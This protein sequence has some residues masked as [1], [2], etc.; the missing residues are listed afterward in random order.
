VSDSAKESGEHLEIRGRP[1]A[2]RRLNRKTIMM[3]S[4][5]LL[6][7]VLLTTIWSLRGSRRG[8]AL[9]TTESHNV[10]HVS[11]PEGLDA[12]PHDYGSVAKIP[13]LGPPIGELGRPIVK[14]EQLAGL[15]PMPERGNFRPD[16]EE[17]A[18]RTEALRQESE[19]KEAARAPVFFQLSQHD[20]GKASHGADGGGTQQAESDLMAV[21]TG[22]APSNALPV[23]EKP[24]RKEAFLDRQAD[25]NLYALGT[26]QIPRS[27]DELLAGTVIPAA[28]VTGINSDLPGEVIATVTETVYDTITGKRA[29]IP[30][31]SRLLGQYDSQ[32]SFG[33][34]RLLL[35]WTR[36]IRPDGSSI[37]LDRLNGVDTEGHAGLQDKIDGHWGRVFAG[38]AVSTLVGVA[39]AL[40][41]PDRTTGSGTLVIASQQS[42]QDSVNQVGQQIT[43]RNIDIQPTLN[44]RPGF[45]LRVIV[46]KDLILRPYPTDDAA[47]EPS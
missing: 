9:T 17:D 29:L 42:V 23:G 44:I 20:Q 14:A 27:P 43:R 41:S 4:A 25:A 3:A 12:L 30:Q 18:A 31:G 19:I 28:L 33:Q 10:D 26:L 6:S 35:V 22:T 37:I 39:A 21:R 8:Q 46:N 16:P 1:Q 13:K 5:L 38:A 2:V 36:L 32:V 7:V 15:T 11:R 24:D 47:R 34:Q 40:A 45:E